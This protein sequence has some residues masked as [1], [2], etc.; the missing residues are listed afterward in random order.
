MGLRHWISI[1][2]VGQ[3]CRKR[4]LEPHGLE[5]EFRSKNTEFRSKN[6]EFRSIPFR[7]SVARFFGIWANLG[8]NGLVLHRGAHFRCFWL[9]NA[10]SDQFGPLPLFLAA[11][12][13][14]GP[15]RSA[16]ARKSGSSGASVRS[17]WLNV[18]RCRVACSV[19]EVA[20]GQRRCYNTHAILTL[21]PHHEFADILR[22]CALFVQST[23]ENCGTSQAVCAPVMS[24]PTVSGCLHVFAL[25]SLKFA[26]RRRLPAPS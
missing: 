4:T 24:L 1:I 19:A 25:H 21:R 3:K 12:R 23:D 8:Q 14:F 22:L 10:L 13:V 20:F 5:A 17:C 18:P 2:F 15:I 9:P 6:T 26:G 16:P 7:L 11:E